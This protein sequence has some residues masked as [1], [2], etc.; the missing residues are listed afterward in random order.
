MPRK[1]GFY[2]RVTLET[3]ERERA[4]PVGGDPPI[5]LLCVIIIKACI[6]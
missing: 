3:T 4:S 5:K 6:D 1:G 2:Q